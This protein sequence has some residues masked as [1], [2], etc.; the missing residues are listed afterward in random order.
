DDPFL[1]CT[2]AR[3][4]RSNYSVVN[5]SGPYLGAYQFL[6]STW[7]ITTQHAGRAELVGV[8]PN[9]ASVYD[10]DDMAWTLYQWQGTGPWGGAC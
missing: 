5:P 3:E 10:Q 4:S 8:P 9:V 7:N 1:S 6:Q 2:R